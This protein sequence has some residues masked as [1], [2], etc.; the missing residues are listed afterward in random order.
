MLRRGR[1][2]IGRVTVVA[3]PAGRPADAVVVEE[4]TW[5]VLGAPPD[6]RE[7][8]EHPLRVLTEAH[9]AQP[10]APGSVIVREGAPLRLLAVVHDVGAEPNWR[11]EWVAAALA[12]VLREAASRRVRSIVLPVL[13]AVHGSLP[14][15]TFAGLLL[16]AV[17][18]G[19]AALEIR[20]SGPRA[21]EALAALRG[22]PGTAARDGG[23][24][25]EG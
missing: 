8:G 14:L 7:P 4:D 16:D 22:A 3:D 25:E 18:P 15:E 24:G 12:G 23:A 5:L 2:R 17:G 21:A 1:L 6:V 13:G 19:D 11:E 10:A 9:D 20:L